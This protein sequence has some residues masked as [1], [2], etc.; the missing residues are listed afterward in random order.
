MHGFGK[1]DSAEG[2]CYHVSGGRVYRE[3]KKVYIENGTRRTKRIIRKR[4]K[5]RNCY[6][7]GEKK[8]IYLG[9]EM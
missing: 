5:N 4:K 9:M 1:T 7:E 6:M 8:N 2:G 3:E